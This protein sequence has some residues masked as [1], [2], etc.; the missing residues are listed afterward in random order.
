MTPAAVL[1]VRGM[2]VLGVAAMPINNPL[3]RADCTA[4]DQT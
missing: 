1:S 3:T 4:M 2:S